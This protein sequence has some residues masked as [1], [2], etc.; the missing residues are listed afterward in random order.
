MQAQ[1]DDTKFSFKMTNKIFLVYVL[2]DLP[3]EYHTV[4]DGLQSR[5]LK[6]GLEELKIKDIQDKLGYHFE[7]IKGR[8]SK[9][10]EKEKTFSVTEDALQNT[11][12]INEHSVAVCPKQFKETC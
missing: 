9:K 4:L 1:I 6:K 10:A 3:E 5:L 2:N 11:N 8:S 12:L 7:V